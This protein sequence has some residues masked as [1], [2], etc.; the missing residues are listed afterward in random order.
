MRFTSF[1][2]VTVKL[3]LHRFFTKIDGRLF[4]KLRA[5]VLFLIICST[6]EI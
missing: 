4:S 2:E 3:P 5:G 1:R 6:K